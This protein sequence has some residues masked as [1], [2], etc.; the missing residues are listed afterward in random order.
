LTVNSHI[1]FFCNGQ[2]TAL[3]LVKATAFE[4]EETQNSTSAKD[5][6]LLFYG[7]PCRSMLPITIQPQ[8]D[9]LTHKKDLKLTKMLII[10]KKI[11]G[12]I[13]TIICLIC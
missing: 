3:S 6:W 8:Y 12:K 5:I 1:H 9:L 10:S 2:Q 11:I 4:Y 7:Q 13:K